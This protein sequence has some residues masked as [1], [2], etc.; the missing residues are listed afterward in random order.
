M[1]RI[2]RGR[3]TE[4]LKNGNCSVGAGLVFMETLTYLE[5]TSDQCSSIAVLMLARE[6]EEIAKNHY[7]YLRLLHEGNDPSY[8][9]DLAARRQQYI[10]QLEAI[11]L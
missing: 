11:E 9:R 2:L 3:H 10:N 8:R 6:N 5:R 7:D 1:V 4:R